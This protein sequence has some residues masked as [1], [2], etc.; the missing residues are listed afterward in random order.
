[1]KAIAIKDAVNAWYKAKDHKPKFRSR[2]DPKRSCYI[3]GSAIKETGI[4]PRMSGKGLCFSESLPELKM[5]S[6][7]IWKADKWLRALI[8]T[9]DN[10][11]VAVAKCSF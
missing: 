10:C 2:K 8:N 4:Y 7:L 9:P 1:M 6:R 3:L 11:I 5:D